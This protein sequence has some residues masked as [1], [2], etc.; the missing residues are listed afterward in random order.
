MMRSIIKKYAI[1]DIYYRFYNEKKEEN[2]RK[3]KLV[4][5][6]LQWVSK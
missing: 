3:W 6:I 5:R 4:E 1:N 2:L